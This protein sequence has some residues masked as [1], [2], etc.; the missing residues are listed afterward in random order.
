MLNHDELIHQAEAAERL[1]DLVSYRADKDR[2]LDQAATLR[3]R[4]AILRPPR[5][6]LSDDE[7]GDT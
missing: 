1:A 7:L 6:F 2:L 4:A 5:T 3:R